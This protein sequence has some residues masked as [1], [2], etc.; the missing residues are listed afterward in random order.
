MKYLSLTISN[1]QLVPPAGVPT[2]GAG[3]TL[4]KIIGV[5]FD[6]LIVIAVILCLFYLIWGGINWIMSEGD[7]Q[8][9]NQAREKVLFAIIGIMVVFGAFLIINFIF[10]LFFH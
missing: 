7:K 8:K 2:G 10:S 1:Q 3:F 4:N 5:G 9:L 6:V